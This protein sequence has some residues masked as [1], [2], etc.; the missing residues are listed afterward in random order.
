MDILEIGGR[1][2]GLALLAIA[3]A[4]AGAVWRAGRSNRDFGMSAAGGWI[5]LGGVLEIC[6][7]TATLVPPHTSILMTVYAGLI[8]PLL[9]VMGMSI[10]IVLD[11]IASWANPPGSPRNRRVV[12]W[13]V[14]AMV[15]AGLGL[16]MELRTALALHMSMSSESIEQSTATVEKW[17]VL[18]RTGGGV[19]AL[20][21]VAVMLEGILRAPIIPPSPPISGDS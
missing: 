15:L 16:L 21:G 13:A 4:W 20:M 8:P 12:R 14:M 10:L 19:A 18:A 9:V 7:A 5:L 17:F 1:Y 6:L 11:G 3:L 2:T